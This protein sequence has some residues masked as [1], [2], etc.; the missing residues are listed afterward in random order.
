MQASVCAVGLAR[1][2]DHTV[3]VSPWSAL[4]T[5]QWVIDALIIFLLSAIHVLTWMSI[6]TNQLPDQPGA[7]DAGRSAV[8]ASLTATG[9][10][11]PLTVIAV[12]LSSK[13]IAQTD[14]TLSGFFIASVCFL[15]SLCFGLYVFVVSSYK[16]A[17]TTP[18]FFKH[19]SLGILLGF[20]LIWLLVGSL[21]LVFAFYGLVTTAMK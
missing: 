1:G 10:L 9:I 3:A 17:G 2:G 5:W 18:N 11:L 4:P 12:Q 13:A 19:K 7:S 6:D 16:A 15:V 21:Q 20:Q 14:A 8:S